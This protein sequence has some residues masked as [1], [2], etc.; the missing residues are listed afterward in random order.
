MKEVTENWAVQFREMK[1]NEQVQCPA[2]SYCVVNATLH[3]LEVEGLDDNVQYSMRLNRENKTIIV[4]R[5][6]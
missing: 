5:R 4:T 1:V 2:R 6:A 3:R